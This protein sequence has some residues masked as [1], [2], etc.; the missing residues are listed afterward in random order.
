MSPSN[1]VKTSVSALSGGE[2]VDGE[3]A[4]AA[5]GLPAGLDRLR[6]V[7]GGGRLQPRGAGLELAAVALDL[8]SSLA[9]GAEDAVEL[10]DHALLREV[11]RVGRRERGQQPALVGAVVEQRHLL[12]RVRRAELAPPGRVSDRR[13]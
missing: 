5:A 6:R 4:G 13:W 7:P 2:A 1:V 12:A 3:V 10:A 9:Q 11:E 8:S